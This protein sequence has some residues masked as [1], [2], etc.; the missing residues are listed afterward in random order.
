MW[1]NC[2]RSLIMPNN[3]DADFEQKLIDAIYR[4]ACD[5]VALQRVIDLLGQ[6]FGSSGVFLGEIDSVVPD[7]QFTVGAGTI[8]D[9]FMSE[10]AEFAPLDPAPQRFASL[11][12]GRASTTDRMFSGDFLR[13]SVFLNEFFR[14]HGIESTLASPLLSDGGRFAIVGIHQG[15]DQERFDDDD[16]VAL[17]RLTPHLSRA[18]QI[19]RLFLQNALRGRSLEALLNRQ[20]A[21]LIG[22]A[23]GSA[24]FVNDA[25]RAIANAADGVGIDRDGRL[26]VADR[27]ATI[28]LKALEAEVRRG[29]P[30]GVVRIRRPSGKSGYFVLIAPLP[31]SEDILLNPRRGGVLIAIHDPSRRA[32]AAVHHI[33]QLLHVPRGAAKVVEA[34]LNGVDL[35]EYAEREGIS[36]HTVKFH[37]KTAFDRTGTRSQTDLARKALLALADLGPFLED[38]D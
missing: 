20:S 36:S 6:Y 2:P 21:G 1:F 34:I 26:M 38:A 8:D 7:A 14:P 27:S 19:R 3:I 31:A 35:K 16:I 30:G 11:A 17:E 23:E 13:T 15:R 22:L 25:A 12:T 37:L 4:G 32:T 9:A 24:L 5:P 10:Y 18:L 28:R 33:G 29:G